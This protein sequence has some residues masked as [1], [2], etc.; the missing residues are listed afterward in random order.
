MSKVKFK[1]NIIGL[2]ELMRSADMRQALNA[3]GVS[4]ENKAQTF[5]GGED[6]AHAIKV[7]DY[8]ALATVYPNSNEAYKAVY[9]DN[10]L[11]KSLSGLPRTK[12]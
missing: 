9:K 8:T 12:K 1:L 3:A 5:S 6:F 2:R 7:L 4:V 11:E 10:I